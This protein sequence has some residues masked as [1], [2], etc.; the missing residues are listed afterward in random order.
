MRAAVLTLL[1]FLI[2]AAPAAAQDAVMSPNVEYL[3]SIKQDVGLTTGAKVVG[4]RLFV[5]SGKNISI[6]DISEPAA[7]KALGAMTATSPGRTRRCRPTARCWR[8]RATSTRSVPG[9]RGGAG[10][11]R[12]RAVL[13]RPR[14]GQHQAGRDD[15][16]RQPHGRVRARLPVLLR[17]ARARSSTRAGI[18]DGTRAEGGRQLDRRARR[19]RAW[20]QESCHHIREI[21]PG[22]LLTACQPFAVIS[23]NAEDGGSPDA[24][25]GALHGRGGEVRA[26]RAL[27]AQGADKFVLIGGEE[28]F[29]GRCELQQ[30]RVLDLQRR[31]A[32]CAGSR[33]SS[34][35]RWT[36]SRRRA[37]AP[38]STASRSPAPSAARSTGSRS[39]RRSAT[40]AWS[41]CPS[42]RT[43]SGSCRS[44]PTA[45][46]T[47]QGY[48]LSLGGSSSSPKWARQ[49]RHPLLDRLPARDRH[50]AL[51]GRALRARSA[52]PEPGRVP[53]RTAP[54]R[55]AP[56]APRRPR[57]ATRW[58]AQLR[59]TGWS[60]GLC[61]LAGAR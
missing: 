3:G 7:P 48:F 2:A 16:D 47:E 24:P 1:T 36:R 31:A 51:E 22:V 9:V 54:R 29:T 5:T 25:E 59:A 6:Y 60:P 41:R 38:T 21:R 49:G 52:A 26:L 53:G 8:S 43:A 28:N 50:P 18:L 17:P 23:I 11:D 57:S 4:N 55:P 33:R 39:T 61:S 45:R 10:R 20:T 58:P 27:A 37:T 46:S 12:L 42:T 15:P 30:Q 32:C 35:A 19:R 34:R 40:A 13:R 56:D 44:T 14:P